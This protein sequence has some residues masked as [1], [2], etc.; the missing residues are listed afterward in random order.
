MLVLYNP[1]SSARRKPVM[2]LD[3]EG[4]DCRIGKHGDERAC[5]QQVVRGDGQRV[6]PQE[7]HRVPSP[8]TER[9]R[10]RMRVAVW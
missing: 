3:F 4:A 9:L 2:P 6:A 7:C 1:P 10:V 8:L 5:E